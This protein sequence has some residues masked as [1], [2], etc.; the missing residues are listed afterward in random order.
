[1]R[2]HKTQP[3]LLLVLKISALT[4]AYFIVGKCALLLAIPPGYATAVWP[5]AGVALSALL[6][7]GYRLWPGVLLGSLLVNYSTTSHNLE[8]SW[9]PLLITAALGTG[10]AAQSLVGAYLVKRFVNAYHALTLEGNTIRL[11]ILGGPVACLVNAL[12]GVTTLVIAG[13]VKPSNA[14][15]SILTWWV[16]DTIGV[17]IFT[18]LILIWAVREIKLK[19]KLVVSVPLLLMFSLVVVLFVNASSWEQK[20]L[21][22]EFLRRT[23]NISLNLRNTIDSYIEVLYTV[24]DLFAANPTIN[25]DQFKKFVVRS[26]N[27]NPGIHAISFNQYIR[28]D[29]RKEYEN[30]ISKTEHPGFHILDLDTNNNSLIPSPAQ[31]NYVFVRYIEPFETN[32]LALGA[33]VVSDPIRSIAMERALRLNAPV[34]TAP[35]Y[36][37][38]EPTNRD[39]ILILLPIFTNVDTIGLDQR[40]SNLKGFVAGVFVVTDIVRQCTKSFDMAGID[41]QVLDQSVADPIYTSSAPIATEVVT[42]SSAKPSDIVFQVSQPFDLA[43]RPFLIKYSVTQDYQAAHRTWQAWTLLASGLLLTGLLEAILLMITG[44]T[45]EVESLVTKRTD[46]LKQSNEA[47]QSHVAALE[48]AEATVRL[49]AEI[50]EKEI[51]ERQRVEEELILSEKRF[52]MLTSN[53]PVGIFQTDSEGNCIYVNERWIE[54]TGL[55][56]KEALGQGWVKALHPEDKESI[57]N[58]WYYAAAN[59]LE[60]SR[61][62][63]YLKP[64]GTINWVHGNAISLRDKAGLVTSFLGTVVDMTDRIRLQALLEAEKQILEMI[65]LKEPLLDTL[66]R[67]AST[68]EDFVNGCHCSIL[69]EYNLLLHQFIE[70]DT[71]LMHHH[72]S[73]T[74]QS[75]NGENLA[76][77]IVQFNQ[78]HILIDDLMRIVDRLSHLAVIAI[79]RSRSEEELYESNENL[80]RYNAELEQLAYVASHD[81][82]EPLR[83]VSIY[84]ELMRDDLRG[85]LDQSTDEYMAYV[86]DGAVRIQ[87]MV[88]DLLAYS[89]VDRGSGQLQAVDCSA[90]ID[91]VLANFRESIDQCHAIVRKGTLP[92][93]EGYPS[94][95]FQLFYNLISNSLTYKGTNLLTIDITA[96]ERDSDWLFSFKDN[97]IGIDPAYSKRIFQ[98]FQRLHGKSE[99]PGMGLGLALCKKIVEWHGGKIWVESQVGDGA[100]FLFNLPKV[101]KKANH[102]YLHKAAFNP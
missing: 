35:L 40:K 41:V 92:V 78:E 75:Q 95:L 33:N 64:D 73:K 50:L 66:G 1:M 37:V 19:R 14:P 18:P 97:G 84:T 65:A 23:E 2:I 26:I 44:R 71:E 86:I 4:F 91:A 88:K 31:D 42:T 72:W 47:L 54:L 12:L 24:Q 99:Y 17:I 7:F 28:G 11:L 46:E 57:F 98:I 16:G 13:I 52:R 27:R 89:T 74:I 3:V 34:A 63:R 43:G 8:S 45:A 61:E 76:T 6:L 58:D 69:V 102:R 100:N 30:L 60:F 36:L 85:E 83:M 82:Q 67:I 51:K 81:L 32:R 87:M 93:V 53:A 10:A 39:G 25:R 21:H 59:Q 94:Q 55:T 15:F 68:V 5:A 62:Y 70:P 22:S 49:K 79:E 20:R 90:M 29:Q 77:L 48:L 80:K 38:Q 9:E 96:N 56:E 101:A